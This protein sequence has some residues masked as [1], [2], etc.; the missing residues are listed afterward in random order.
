MALTKKSI[1]VGFSKTE[2]FVTNYH[3]DSNHFGVIL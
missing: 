2:S 3:F 1:I